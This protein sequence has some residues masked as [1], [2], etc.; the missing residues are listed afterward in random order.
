MEAP[1]VEAVHRKMKDKVNVIGVAWAG[2]ESGYADFMERHGL[3]FPNISDTE[4][5]V[6]AR[7][8]VPYQPA[9]VYLDTDGTSQVRR[10]SMNEITALAEL[11]ALAAD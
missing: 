3:T 11:E 4:G 7:Y 6:Y 10:G 8:G 1:S 5:E 9:W 2:T